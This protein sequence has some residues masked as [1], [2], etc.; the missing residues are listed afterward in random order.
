MQILAININDLI[1]AFIKQQTPSIVDFFHE[2]IFEKFKGDMYQITKYCR[3]FIISLLFYKRKYKFLNLYH[4]ILSNF[5]D[6]TIYDFF[7][8]VKGLGLSMQNLVGINYVNIDKVYLNQ[9]EWVFLLNKS[10]GYNIE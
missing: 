3:T 6:K 8:Q 2:F 1:R 7:S 5:K 9:S 10:L 4:H